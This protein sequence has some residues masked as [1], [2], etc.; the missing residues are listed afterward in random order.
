MRITTGT[1]DLTLSGPGGEVGPDSEFGADETPTDSPPSLTD[2]LFGY[3]AATATPAAGSDSSLSN[4]ALLVDGS[5]VEGELAVDDEAV[6]YTLE[7]VAGDTV[8]IGWER[9][10]GDLAPRLRVLDADGQ[11][12]AQTATPDVVS[13]L[14]LVVF[15]PADG[16]LTLVVTRYGDP[17]EGGDE[18][19]GTFMLSVSVNPS[20]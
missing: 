7:A 2:S 20:P 13:A 14:E 16:A 4:P 6:T 5:V 9:T 18:M 11:L 3:G 19:A 17:V 1:Y 15:V 10:S 12:L 8:V